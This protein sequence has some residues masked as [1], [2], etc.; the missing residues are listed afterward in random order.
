[1]KHFLWY[2]E[3]AIRN[4]WDKPAISNYGA[5]TYTYGGIAG[6]VAKLHILF[7][8]CGLKKGDHI[9]IA[10]RNS[11]E[12]CIAFIAIASYKAVAVPLL[13]DFLP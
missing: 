5:T 13:P 11:A 3:D 12:W 2:I 6:N 1:M 10:S 7:E 4:N 9:A 8:K